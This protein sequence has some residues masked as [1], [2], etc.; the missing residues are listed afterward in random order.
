MSDTKN[1]KVLINQTESLT[2]QEQALV[3]SYLFKVDLRVIPILG[4]VYFFAVMDRANIGAAS[5]NGLREGLNLS[6]A[7]AG[8]ITSFFFIAYVAFQAPANILLKK[9]SPHIWFSFIICAWSIVVMCMA[10]TKTA[11]AFI[12]C[13]FLLGMFECGLT[14]GVVAYMPYWYTRS[15]V[16]FRMSL[17]F[18]AGTLSGVFGGPIAAGLV[19][20][21]IGN[22]APYNTIFLIEGALSLFFGILTYFF[23]EDYPD[24][25]TFLKEEEREIAVRRISNDQG[26]ASQAKN[27]FQSI[28]AAL[29]DWKVWVYSLMFLA[30]NIMGTTIGFFS[31][32]I[33][34]ALGHTSTKATI[35]S[36]FPN[37]AGFV[38][39]VLSS[40]TMTAFPLWL[41]AAVYAL[42]GLIGAAVSGFVL[43]NNTI[44][45]VFLC[46]FGFGTFP[47]IPII[48]TWMSVNSGGISK[49]MIA[50]AM[51][52]SFGGAS[53]LITP[54]FNLKEYAPKFRVSFLLNIVSS[55]FIL[56]ASLVLV[57]YYKY[58]NAR[59]DRNP[60]DVSHLSEDEQRALNDNHPSFRYKL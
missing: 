17:F 45:L 40:W 35:Y 34:T 60:E 19:Q 53:G 59:R 7:N 5:A 46:V 54:Y 8:H 4:F 39:Q 2:V 56:V 29:L 1:E 36:S 3:K 52:V 11:V 47:N 18:A 30:V 6:T 24:K 12:A 13:R 21:Q 48:A 16:G 51:T 28:I 23:I 22:L 20:H 50:S 32:I 42:I 44:R 15:E 38:A 26:L 33:I 31:P 49:R 27:S 25:C 58:E 57:A 9:F 10:A 37:L 43:N 14:P 41:N 55:A